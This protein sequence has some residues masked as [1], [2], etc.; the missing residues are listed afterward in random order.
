MDIIKGIIDYISTP[1][2]SFTLLT[3]A[4]PFIFPPSDWFDK[5]NR[6]WGI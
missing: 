3:I 5:K 2:I 6:D 4:F 1:T